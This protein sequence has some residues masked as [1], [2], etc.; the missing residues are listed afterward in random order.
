[1]IELQSALWP[2]AKRRFQPI[3]IEY[4]SCECRKYYSYVNGT[5]QFEG[6]N[7]FHPGQDP[8]LA[9]D[10]LAAETKGP[11]STSNVF[12][13][14]GAPCSGKTTL[15]NALE[16]AGYKVEVFVAQ[17]IS[18]W[19]SRDFSGGDCRVGAQERHLSRGLFGAD[20]GGPYR[21]AV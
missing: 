12:V 21:V 16:A 6:K 15:L 1:M 8:R 14:A 20:E 5:K 4:L 19:L 18:K 17:V 2:E 13:I 3:D 11:P 7:V 10:I 9:F